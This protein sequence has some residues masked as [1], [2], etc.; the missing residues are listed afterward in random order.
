V[1]GPL[2]KEY[3]GSFLINY[4]YSTVSVLQK[5]GLVNVPGV[6]TTFQDAAFKVVLP[7]KNAGTFSLFG[8]GG[9]D[10]LFVKNVS[11]K[12]WKT[13]GDNYMKPQITQDFV[14]GNYLANMGLNHTAPINSNS[15]L[16]STLCY[17][18]IGLQDDVIESTILKTVNGMGEAS[19]DTVGRKHNFKSKIVKS[20]Y[21]G[22]SIYCN[23]INTSH[24]IE[25][26]AEYS[27]VNENNDQSRLEN[28]STS[29]RFSLLFYHGNIQTFQTFLSWKYNFND[30]L[31]FVSGLHNL[32]VLLNNKSTFEPRIALDYKFGDGNSITAGYGKHSKMETIH[33][34]FTQVKQADGNITEPNKKLDV[35]KADHFVLGYNKNFTRNLNLK[36]ETYYQNLYN[37]PVEDD[38]ASSYATIN[39]GGDYK[40]VPLVN[41]G[42]GANY[43]IELTLERI[44]DNQYYYLINGSFYNSKYKT[45][46]GIE[47]NTAYNSNYLFNLLCG[48]E[49][50]FGKRHN[51]TLTLNGKLFFSGGQRYIPLV[52]DTQGNLAVD[53]AN[54]KF[55]DYGEAY[56]NK[57]DDIFSLDVSV[58][59]KINFRKSTHE[60]FFS[61]TNIT[62]NQAKLSEY[63]DVDKPGNIGYIYQ[64]SMMPNIIYRGYF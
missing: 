55:W 53:P 56:E 14:Q 22:M 48:R 11:P 45:L 39:E 28:D 64:M 63:Y 15:Y 35:L 61:L 25:I 60:L 50:I 30:N 51:N 18:G 34:Y 10:S 2:K 9:I 24:K 52:R 57:F 41:K 3:S 19:F 21:K 29:D 38:A 17:S 16:Q 46:D 12:I 33:N 37:L 59:Y 54:N 47:R 31:T 62:K 13:P 5:L 44:F 32:N 40:Y 26:G 6:T 8:L 23:K 7:S 36:I 27:I 1:E 42:T 20:N 43:G 4:R 58:S 49:F